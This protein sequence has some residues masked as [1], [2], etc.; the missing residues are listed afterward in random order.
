MPNFTPTDVQKLINV[1]SNQDLSHLEPKMPTVSKLAS[2]GSSLNTLRYSSTNVMGLAERE[3]ISS[4]DV[5]R[6]ASTNDLGVPIVLDGQLGEV[7]QD[8][9]KMRA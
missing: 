2:R 7:N 5:T 9:E 3:R 6:V 4:K 8:M 1:D